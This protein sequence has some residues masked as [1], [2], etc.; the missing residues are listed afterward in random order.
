M[1][2]ENNLMFNTANL[3]RPIIETLLGVLH[4]ARYR[5][6]SGASLK[7][8]NHHGLGDLNAM[9]VA[10]TNGRIT[11]GDIRFPVPDAD[12][13]DISFLAPD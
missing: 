3:P 1:V 10:R 12:L 5:W 6:N 2:A 13:I 8:I 9:L 4:D 11:V 7:E